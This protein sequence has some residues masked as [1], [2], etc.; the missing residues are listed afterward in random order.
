MSGQAAA[1]SRDRTQR[2]RT[3]VRLRRAATRL[4]VSLA[5]VGLL[6]TIPTFGARSAEAAALATANA[7]STAMSAC[8]GQWS[9]SWTWHW[10]G[11]QWVATWTWVWVDCTGAHEVDIS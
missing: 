9:G 2:V 11:K 8:P 3:A 4:V 7:D 10:N 6:F 1:I 5:I